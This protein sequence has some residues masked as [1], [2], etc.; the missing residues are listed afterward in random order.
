[1]NQNELYIK[2]NR[3]PTF[4]LLGQDYLRLESGID[5]FLSEVL[6][7]YGDANVTPSSYGQLFDG[8]AY[9]EGESALAWMQSLCDRL[10]PPQWL[11]SIALFPW[12]GVYSSAIDVIW[13]RALRLERRE[14]QPVMDVKYRP[15]D[16]RNRSKL[17]CTFFFGSVSRVE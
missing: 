11:K 17:L 7:K 15:S 9:K 14:L 6:R 10:S 2:I 12:N 5:P 16:P 3:G 4:L 13:M 1:M 8:E